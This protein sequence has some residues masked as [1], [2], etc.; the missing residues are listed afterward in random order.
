M[1]EFKNNNNLSK[2]QGY[3]ISTEQDERFIPPT[4]DKI[5]VIIEEFLSSNLHSV[6]YLDGIEHLIK[7]NDLESVFKFCNKIKDSIVLND[8]IIIISINNT[9]FENETLK[10]LLKNS[11]NITKVEVVFEDLLERIF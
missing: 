10:E 4:L 11:I 2:I 1:E 3:Q 6:I 8:S 9:S 5:A 7:S